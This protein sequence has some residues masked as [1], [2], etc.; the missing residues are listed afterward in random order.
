MAS[1]KAAIIV[2]AS[3]GIGAALARKLGRKGWKLALVARRESELQ[4]VAGPINRAAPGRALIFPH[5]VRI[6]PR[7]G[8]SFRTS[9]TS[10][11]GST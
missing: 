1:S 5:D 9:F 4:A 8:R 10:S 11:A 2:G 7:P 6:F 3:S